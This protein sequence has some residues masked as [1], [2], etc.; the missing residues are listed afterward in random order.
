M[1]RLAVLFFVF[2]SVAIFAK[3]DDAYKKTSQGV[4]ATIQ[5][6]DV[7]VEF[8]SPSIV[9]VLKSP[10]GQSIPKQSIP[11]QSLSV[12]KMPEA[13]KIKTQEKGGIVTIMSDVLSVDLDL[14][15]GDITFSHLK[16]GQLLKE[17][18]NGTSFEDFDDAGK[19]SY[20]VKQSFDLEK[21]EA[22]YGLGQIQNGSMQQRNETLKLKNSNHDITIPY[23]YS[24][25]GYSVFWDNYASTEYVDD[26][27][28]TSFKSIG[29]CADYYF[30]FGGSGL[31]TIKQMRELSGQAPMFPLWTFGYWQSKERYKTQ[32]EV[33]DV[34]KKYRE[35]QIPIDGMIQDWRYWGEDSV[36]NSMLWNKDR[37]PDPNRFTKEVH[38]LNA[39]LMVVA[40]P[41]FGPKTEQH[42][43][44]KKKNM[45]INFDT[46]PPK[47]GTKPY[48]VYNP[49]ARDIYW[50]Y[51]NKG[52]FSKG[53]DA[54]W[55]DSTEPD[56]INVKPEDF[57]QPT[58]LGS[59]QSV[60][61]AFSLMHTTGIYNNQ[62]K[63]TDKKRVFILTRSSFA[64]QQRNAANS[65][66]GDVVSDWNVL[67]TQIS[68]AL[69]FSVCGV[70]YWNSDIGGF[71]TWNFPG[72]KDNVAFREIYVRWL[73]FGTF[74][75][76][77]R[78][79]G[80]N[81]PREIWQFGNRGDWEFDAIEKY[82]Q[83]RYRML[84]YLYST[85]WQVTSNASTFMKPLVFDFVNDK[86]VYDID[87]QYMF[88]E[89]FLVCP[90]TEAMYTQ[91]DKK[92]TKY[93]NAKE[94]F[95]SI[96]KSQVYLPKGTIWY[97]FWIGEK[98]QG[99]QYI[100]RETPIDI[101]PIYVKAGSI[102]PWGPDVQYAE[103][104]KWDKLEIRIYPGADGEF[105]LY[106][107]ENDNYNYEKGKY[108]SISFKWNDKAK[109]LTIGERK[110]EFDGMISNREFKIVIVNE[111]V[112]SGIKES[113][114]FKSVSFNGK[115][116]VVSFK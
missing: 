67:R 16:T 105:L 63:T 28:S 33:V 4:E 72:G 60:S 10:T 34:L 84:P 56:H 2:L 6:I 43:L 99:G 45:L 85:S 58:Y 112:G 15:S 97:D 32:F 50:D 53:V 55:L 47:S 23:F 38:D 22:I 76:M 69:N 104:K 102:I 49:A 92:D 29:D 12:T 25:K 82:I 106:E 116:Q 30:M 68:A 54:W 9:R 90:V 13:L 20:L 78:S 40:W 19:K 88:G 75:P 114:D 83:L 18:Q 39:H 64:G 62:R 91:F 14:K 5:K 51:L 93:V 110:G 1:R 80:T 89:S 37:Y 70:P 74:C 87:N 86:E 48:D 107:D 35:L 11:K 7:S 96:I 77:M 109:K 71:F 111:N 81:T 73:Q 101:M 44:F 113:A 8:Y 36:W 27:N 52:V 98:L 95:S 61:N 59:Y 108:S 3:N 65:W 42:Q 17:L 94:D 115:S 57:T 31:G 26:E 100:E 79:H 21:D 41:G 66:S 46:W 24:N 103:E